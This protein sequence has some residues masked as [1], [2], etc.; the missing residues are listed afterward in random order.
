M[1][2]S[3]K[4]IRNLIAVLAV[5]LLII[6]VFCVK[7]AYE[8]RC[9]FINCAPASW[10]E[11]RDIA[12]AQAGDNFRIQYIS[13]HPAAWNNF[14]ETGPGFLDLTVTYVSLKPDDSNTNSGKY[15]QKYVEFDD[16][17]LLVKIRTGNS[18]SNGYPSNISKES[19]ERL[20][21]VTIHPRDAFRTTWK[22]AETALSHPPNNE[23]T[24]ALLVF[25]DK[26]KERFGCESIWVVNYIYNDASMTFRVD[27]QTGQ[28]IS[29]E[30]TP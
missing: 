9:H 14:T 30:K 28:V 22:L 20:S 27:A 24:S 6:L 3:N 23:L 1:S 16:R 2:K 8:N 18:W 7:A 4:L 19:Q 10:N 5:P 12:L 17:S 26:I 25:D 13:A 21:K 15:S 11:I 29:T